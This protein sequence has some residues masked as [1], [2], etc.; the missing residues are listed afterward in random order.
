MQVY[1]FKWYK[2]YAF[3]ICILTAASPVNGSQRPHDSAPTIQMQE[4]KNRLLSKYIFY[5]VKLLATSERGIDNNS[6]GTEYFPSIF[7]L[8]LKITDSFLV[9]FTLLLWWSTS[10]LVRGADINAERQIRA[11]VGFDSGV[12]DSLVTTAPTRV[13][14]AIK[15]SGLTPAHDVRFQ[16]SVYWAPLPHPGQIEL[17]PPGDIVNYTILMQEGL[18]AVTVCTSVPNTSAHLEAFSSKSHAIWIEGHITYKDVFRK[19]R[20]TNFVMNSNS[21]NESRWI[22]YKINAT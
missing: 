5:P 1:V 20:N 9:F 11:Y 2:K 12:I 14:V 22:T 16:L 13:H 18:S 21:T 8:R 3:F 6:E 17:P 19:E 7:G 10:R 4:S 15:N